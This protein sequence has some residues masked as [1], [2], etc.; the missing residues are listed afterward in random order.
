MSQLL[1]MANH[2]PR[3]AVSG[4]FNDCHAP[5]YVQ[6]FLMQ[7]QPESKITTPVLGWLEDSVI[8][9]DSPAVGVAESFS[10]CA[11]IWIVWLL[12]GPVLRR[13]LPYAGST[14]PWTSENGK[15]EISRPE[16]ARQTPQVWHRLVP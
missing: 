14:R 13:E 8:R 1:W 7:G 4:L 16:T 3:S 6:N 2:S 5:Y 9:S 15:R 10:T 11:D 12:P